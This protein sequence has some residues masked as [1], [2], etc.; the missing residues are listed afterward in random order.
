MQQ[1]M[2]NASSAASIDARADLGRTEEPLCVATLLSIAGG[3]PD[4]F[5][6]IAHHDVIV[7]CM[8]NRVRQ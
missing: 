3:F 1:S 6:W 7:L 4:A 5:T 8:R 2:Q